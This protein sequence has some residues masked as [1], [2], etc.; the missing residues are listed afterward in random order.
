MSPT[1]RYSRF[2]SARFRGTWRRVLA[3][4]SSMGLVL[5]LAV[6][7]GLGSG[8]A[9]ADTGDLPD[10]PTG[11]AHAYFK[12]LPDSGTP[13]VQEGTTLK[14]YVQYSDVETSGAP[15]LQ[16]KTVTL[17]YTGVVDVP[18]G[19]IAVPPGNDAIQSITG[20]SG[21]GTIAVAFKSIW[22]SSVTEGDFEL[23]LTVKEVSGN[24]LETLQWKVDAGGPKTLTII[25]LDR[26][27]PAVPTASKLTKSVADSTPSLGTYVT[28][29]GTCT[30]P[31]SLSIADT[32]KNARIK[33]T[34]T[35]DTFGTA[36]SGYT[37]T[38]KLA[39]HLDYDS[40]SFN[41]TLIT[42]DDTDPLVVST[43]RTAIVAQA[44]V[45]VTG[46]PEASTFSI[47]AADLPD[48]IF[49]GGGA[50]HSL[51]KF[52]RLIL[53]YDAL[54]PDD[55]EVAHLQTAL[56]AATGTNGGVGGID[57]VL[58]M[59]NDAELSGGGTN[60]SHTATINI[61]YH[62]S[63]VTP[64]NSFSKSSDWTTYYLTAIEAVDKVNL[65]VPIAY[66]LTA[67]LG[68]FDESTEYRKLTSDV[69]LT[70]T[71]PVGAA[72]D[73]TS[74]PSLSGTLK[75][76]GG[77]AA[78]LVRDTDCNDVIVDGAVGHYCISGQALKVNVGKHKD[79]DVVIGLKAIV[80]D[81]SAITPESNWQNPTGADARKITNTVGY[82]VTTSAYGTFSGTKPKDVYVVDR[83]SVPGDGLHDTNV[84]SKSADATYT[85]SVGQRAT[86]PYSFV[87]DMA[88]SGVQ[89][90]GEN[91][92]AGVWDIE[93]LEIHDTV[94]VDVFD[95]DTAPVIANANYSTDNTTLV[96][97]DFTVTVN[98]LTGEIAVKLSTDG[99]TKLSGKAA[100]RLTFEL[101]LTTFPLVG[102]QTLLVTNRAELW[103][104][105]SHP[106]YWS[107]TSSDIT[108]YGNEAEVRKTVW[109]GAD[110]VSVLKLDESSTQKTFVYQLSFI[111]HGGYN[112]PAGIVGA[113]DK[114]PIG[115]VFN[116]FVDCSDP[117]T[118]AGSGPF[119]T[120]GVK[121]EYVPA[122]NSV[123]ISKGS[124]TF[125]KHA[126]TACIQVTVTDGVQKNVPLVNKLGR[127]G[128]TIVKTSGYPLIVAKVD[129]SDSPADPDNATVITD[130]SARFTLSK[131]DGAG[132]K[133]VV[134]QDIFV[135]DG[136]LRVGSDCARSTAVIVTDPGRYYLTEVIPPTAP[137]VYEQS[138]DELAIVVVAGK[139][140]AEKTFANTP[141]DTSQHPMV[142][143]GNYV[144]F[145]ADKDGL[146]NA[147]EDSTGT[148]SEPGIAGVV[149]R[150]KHVDANGNKTDVTGVNGVLVGPQTTDASGHYLFNGLPP[151]IAGQHYEVC[152]DYGASGSALSGYTPTVK[153]Q[154]GD[155]GLDSSTDCAQTIEALTNNG[156][157]DLSLDFGFVLKPSTG[158]GGDPSTSTSTS[159]TVT[160]TPTTGVTTATTVPPTIPTVT[161]S[162]A[163]SPSTP[164]PPTN[165]PGTTI[166]V[167]PDECTDLVEH[168]FDP[169]ETVTITVTGEHGQYELIAVADANG[170]V[171]FC[172]RADQPETL[173]IEVLGANH[174]VVREVVIG[175]EDLS[176]TGVPT[177][178]YLTFALL[179]LGAGVALTLVGR[180][181]RRGRH[182]AK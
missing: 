30:G 134:R 133:T 135:C 18:N 59:G 152:I 17:T 6:G 93:K 126:H 107:E 42:W 56:R 86:V 29:S 166:P 45:H 104:S 137:K 167:S 71:L 64:G 75:D 150:I 73:E 143:V 9:S 112:P 114:L 38:D 117:S 120:G 51:P 164:P 115:F 124:A 85:V 88:P 14:F 158:G 182:F 147:G 156:D 31:S 173:I 50:D 12:A 148:P 5:G 139:V 111:P 66:T 74:V 161:P 160:T 84:F 10:L 94:D 140:P 40:T 108:T 24:T 127:S 121:V 171:A 49:P 37:I 170:D 80:K 100:G 68:Q 60:L 55:T 178:E 77:S 136:Y 145:D 163:T 110:W 3:A 78:S 20:D 69:V 162:S 58:P 141:V 125:D 16:G 25:I 165:V 82:S 23:E 129:A 172:L 122:D 26:D 113:T 8:V 61:S 92:P 144:W 28:C 99:I 97:S 159:P 175:V 138:A 169:G 91:F 96:L 19:S 43:T 89:N 65:T 32:I 119:D 98:K 7:S 180:R 174:V 109:D 154:G 22:P 83:S 47:G 54:I 79:T 106:L 176:Y 168:G 72:W 27:A 2:S 35:I 177:V 70:D 81:I 21:A 132:G 48:G 118:S 105:E 101:Q 11:I 39:V 149:L 13:Q 146:H 53:T 90:P 116:G 44:S 155:R 36:R 151:L 52:S 76:H 131:D 128:A 130:P 102:K 4:L 95:L 67:N 157:R 153:E 63:G 33:Y 57:Y 62:V 46:N 123:A 87:V 142:S 1:H 15:A 41:A 179:L 34:I 181:G 103:G